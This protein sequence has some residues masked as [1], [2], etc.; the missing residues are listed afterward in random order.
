VDK[1]VLLSADKGKGLEV[2]G[3]FVRRGGSGP[4]LALTLANFSNA[5][6]DGFMVQF[7]KN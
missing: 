7:N 2:R 5:P 1:K 6:M 3:A 4:I